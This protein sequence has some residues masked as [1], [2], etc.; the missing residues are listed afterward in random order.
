MATERESM[1]MDKGSRSGGEGSRKSTKLDL[2]QILASQQD[3][4]GG[5]WV[6]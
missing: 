1:G 6:W 5:I 4:G 3:L 2:N